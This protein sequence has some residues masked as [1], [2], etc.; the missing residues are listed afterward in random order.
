MLCIQNN[1]SQENNYIRKEHTE[2]WSRKSWLWVLLCALGIYSTI[3]LARAF[4][5]L[6]YN[7]VGKEFFTYLAFFLIAI[8]LI[9]LLYF[10]IVKLRIKRISQYVWLFSCTGLYIY[11]INQLSNHPEEAIHIIEYGLLSFFVF[12][13]LSHRIKDWTVYISAAFIV[14]FLGTIDEFLQWIM[15]ARYWDYRDV[16]INFLAGSI[17][18]FAIWKGINPGEISGSVKRYSIRILVIVI[19]LNLITL[20]LCLSNTPLNVNRY[21]TAIGSFTWL[22]QEEAMTEF[23]HKNYDP[24]IGD[25]YSRFELD[26]LIK[27]DKDNGSIYGKSISIDIDSGLSRDDILVKYS[28]GS[29]PFLFEFL[30]H[31]YRIVDKT[32]AFL[33]ASNVQDTSELANTIFKESMII[34]NYFSNTFHNSALAW[35]YIDTEILNIATLQNN[36][37]YISNTGKLITGFDITT[38]RAVILVILFSVWIG[39]EIWMRSLH[40][41]E[42]RINTNSS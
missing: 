21:T 32:K 15:P 26:E 3:P 18:L 12:K 13:A 22:Q 20:G 36:G 29:N 6:V 42:N 39:G 38:A 2:T 5:K 23:G 27:L 40:A 34:K 31:Y 7:S 10:F 4:Q 24:Q 28:P 1:L 19:T 37:S 30:L 11:F 9:T 35:P 25:M 16:G 8:T 17:F 14:M 41:S 33:D